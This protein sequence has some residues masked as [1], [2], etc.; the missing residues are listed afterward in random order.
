MP[1]CRQP[2]LSGAAAPEAGQPSWLAMHAL[3]N[4]PHDH[5]DWAHATV[6][7]GRVSVPEAPP[8]VTWSW[9]NTPWRPL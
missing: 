3:S 8:T 5:V 2:P 4:S 6:A 7:L 9:A 1:A